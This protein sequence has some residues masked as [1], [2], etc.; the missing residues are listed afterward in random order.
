MSNS[1]PFFGNNYGVPP[2][3]LSAS[4]L[5]SQYEKEIDRLSEKVTTHLPDGKEAQ[6]YKQSNM[7]QLKELYDIIKK[8]PILYE[9]RERINN[10]LAEHKEISKSI[11]TLYG[12]GFLKKRKMRKTR[13]TKKTRKMRKTRK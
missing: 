12:I 9:L 5:R 13:K 6:V 2:A 3:S 7:L 10:I 1:P 8:R 11:I 4:H